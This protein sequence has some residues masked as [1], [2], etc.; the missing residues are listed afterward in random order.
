MGKLVSE[1][2]QW[3]IKYESGA[4]EKFERLCAE[5]A[6]A[7]FGLNIHRIV[8]YQG[9]LGIDLVR[10]ECP[11]PE[12]IY[13]CK[14]FGN[15]IE[16][17]QMNQIRKSFYRAVNA[18]EYAL[19]NWVLFLTTDMNSREWIKWSKWK[20]EQEQKFGV[21]ISLYEGSQLIFL[22]KRYRLYDHYFG[23]NK[24]TLLPKSEYASMGLF[25]IDD[26][27]LETYSKGG[28]Q[29][30]Q[31][32]RKIA[33]GLKAILYA[34]C[35]N[36]PSECVLADSSKTLVGCL[37]EEI[38]K[39][40]QMVLL[41][42]NGGIGKTTALVQTA[43]RM[44]TADR[45][46]FLLQMDMAQE[47][48][49]AAVEQILLF[50]AER[51]GWALE[52]H[53]L[54]FIDN[55]Y[56]NSE[57]LGKFLDELQFHPNVQVIMCERLNRFASVADDLIVDSYRNTVRVI[58]AGFVEDKRGLDFVGGSQVRHVTISTLWKRRIVLD[59]FAANPGVDMDKVE[60]LMSNKKNMSIVELYM[61]TCINY[62]RLVDEEGNLATRFKV[63]LDWDEWTRLVRENQ[64]LSSE[65][66]AQM[67]SVFRVVAALDLFKIKASLTMLSNKTGISE[68]RLDDLFSAMLSKTSSE[69]MR[70]E[71]SGNRPF[72]SLKHDVISYLYFDVTKVAL[73]ITLE[74]IVRSLR[75]SETIIS[76]E[77][78]VFKRKYIQSTSGASLPSKV[79]FQSLYRLFAA[80][81]GFYEVLSS[82]DREYSFDIAR[83]WMIDVQKDQG[84][85]ASQAWSELLQCYESKGALMRRK[86]HLCCQ[87]DC[88]RR[89]IPFPKQLSPDRD[90]VWYSEGVDAAKHGV[91]L[92]QIA[93]MWDEKFT[94]IYQTF[95]GGWETI[96]EWRK[97]IIDYFV[98]GFEMPKSFFDVLD[99]VS[100]RSI[101]AEY[102]NLE[103]YVRRNRLNTK[104]Y[105]SLGALLYEAIAKR[106][107]LDI[108]A[109]M[110]LAGCYEC[111][112]K[113]KQAERVYEDIIGK[114]PAH[115]P[116][117]NALAALCSRWLR[118]QREDFIVN[119]DE[120]QRLEAVF[121]DSARCALESAPDDIGKA[122]CHA[123]LGTYYIRTAHQYK[124]GYEAL[125]EGLKFFE[126][127]SL[128]NELGML[129]GFFSNNNKYFSIQKAEEHFCKALSL[130]VP[131]MERLPTYIPYGD[132][133]YCIGMF[134]KAAVQYRKASELGER[135]AD[136]MMELI[137]HEQRVLKKL[138]EYRPR[139]ITTLWNEGKE[140]WITQGMLS[141]MGK[142][143]DVFSLL[144]KAVSDEAPE[145]ADACSISLLITGWET[146]KP[147]T[148]DLIR[149]RVI[150]K[151]EEYCGKDSRYAERAQ[152]NF[153]SQCFF[154]HDSTYIA[155]HDKYERQLKEYEEYLDKALPP[156]I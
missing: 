58:K 96:S 55:P 103:T 35:S 75:D 13:Q 104:R 21:P 80:Q 142:K 98:L 78:Q 4:S 23:V 45:I 40:A 53:Y 57:I 39:G 1:F 7:M 82:V 106:N 2:M 126:L 12:V 38:E 83:V 49:K 99:H 86:V 90:I 84:A 148:H 10:G 125:T 151:L 47:Q 144:L 131:P 16:E 69:P 59:M 92:E 94:I 71:S 50:F 63:N 5:L 18:K 124:K 60:P 123:V 138:A 67:E 31:A 76:F 51:E 121:E 112:K 120:K 109:K 25:L 8:P 88:R 105:Y 139:V 150:Q 81:K 11:N 113:Y 29:A 17:C 97:G 140:I 14:F 152:E 3:K 54:I 68:E 26:E 119:P 15:N 154:I 134:E 64:L 137:C 89:H 6:C 116:A 33:V 85:A 62:N 132:M 87:D 95:E 20:I 9:D 61:R 149:Y 110:N 77:K 72:L 135:K 108:P 28:A 129:Y 127:P 19:K 145:K 70:Y 153:Q 101:D 42:G 146:D 133:L 36:A 111:L 48:C 115:M 143:L 34:V 107:P 32:F 130:N 155:N 27:A 102:S 41:L 52:Y 46:I 122:R 114:N 91:S 44:H 65:E 141:D 43:V 73:Q 156:D 66:K 147:R 117:Y 136:K 118:S 93:A 22:L 79:D 100:Y 128:H 56:V 37:E 74:G 24:K 30:V